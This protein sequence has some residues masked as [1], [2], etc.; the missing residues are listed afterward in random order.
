MQIAVHQNCIR[1]FVGQNMYSY[2]PENI[3]INQ[4]RGW[5]MEARPDKYV[6]SHILFWGYNIPNTDSNNSFFLSFTSLPSSTIY[7]HPKYN[8]P[9]DESQVKF[10]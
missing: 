6:G 7:Y 3:S 9:S 10:C 5:G 2:L 4:G 8:L 1:Q